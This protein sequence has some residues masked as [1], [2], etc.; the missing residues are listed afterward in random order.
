M[1]VEGALT[2]ESLK[3]FKVGDSITYKLD[4]PRK[5]PSARVKAIYVQNNYPELGL[6]FSTH[7]N[8]KD[9][10]ITITATKR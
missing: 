7:S 4:H 5:I 10:T 9:C 1:V 6:K 8:V 2:V 3:S